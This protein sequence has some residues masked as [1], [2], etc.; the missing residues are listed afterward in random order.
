MKLYNLKA[1]IFGFIFLAVL[2]NNSVIYG[3]ASKEPDYAELYPGAE[4]IPDIVYGKGG[5][6][7][8]KLDLF[9]PKSSKPPYFGIIFI[10]GGA[11]RGLSKEYLKEWGYYF[12]N[13]GILAV[14]ID[15]RLSGEAKFPA[16]V[17]DCKCAVRWLRANAGKY[18]V[19]PDKIA[20]FGESAGGHLAALL[21]TS[22][23]VK[24]LEGTGGHEGFSSRPDLVFP[25]YGVLDLKLRAEESR[26]VNDALS[27]FIGCSFYEC[28]DKYIKASPITYI[29][30]TDPPFL[31]FHST[32]DSVV[33]YR[34]SVIFERH[35]KD[36]GVPVEFSTTI[37]GKH[38]YVLWEP[39]FKSTCDQMIYFINKYF[40][41][42]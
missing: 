29:D 41:K 1:Q 37:G 5:E 17:E 23:G 27:E 9:L 14:S 33:P 34:H 36:A 3:Q 21:G 15:Y 32:A 25:V 26:A 10:H 11:W 2:M 38:G 12:A 30:H 42:K 35:L 31:L 13:Q 8:L 19:L 18:Q 7:D 22:G 6:K 4:F 20:V 28:P 16:A 39:H 24:E 40:G